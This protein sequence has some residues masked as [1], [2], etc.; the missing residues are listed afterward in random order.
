[1]PN[2]RGNSL[3][4]LRGEG[5]EQG[6]GDEPGR[7]VGVEPAGGVLG[8]GVHEAVGGGDQPLLWQV[9]AEGPGPLPLIDEGPHAAQDPVV[10][11]ADALRREL[12]LCGQQDV[13][14][15]VDDLP[16]RRDQP[17]ERVAGVA[18]G[19]TASA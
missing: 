12:T 7:I 5:C 1:M 15:L 19:P 17:G 9:A 6:S 8:R 4:H 18:G 11:A 16:R 10:D 3:A 14:E 2:D 13:A